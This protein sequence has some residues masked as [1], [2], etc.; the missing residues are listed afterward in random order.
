MA[1][2]ASPTN[3][4]AQKV[5]GLLTES[6]TSAI[7]HR[8][9]SGS[10]ITPT[11]SDQ[12]AAADMVGTHVSGEA[13]VSTDPTVLIAGSVGG[14]VYPLAAGTSV[15]TGA[16]TLH[17][18]EVGPATTLVTHAI[19]VSTAATAIGTGISSGRKHIEVYNGGTQ[20][21]YVG[22]SAVSTANGYPL[23]TAANSWWDSGHA[24]YAVTAGGTATL[25]VLE[26]S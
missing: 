6:S 11:G 16:S 3:S 26:M 24:W 1:T 2:P 12:N 9:V 19:A 22:H 14:T 10:S 21:V 17:V 4:A 18:R 23:G 13:I 5:D 25:R 15:T 20:V 8:A 7:W